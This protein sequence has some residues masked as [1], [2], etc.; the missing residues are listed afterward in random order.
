[1][2]Q[3]FINA[4]I[5]KL[6]ILKALNFPLP[7]SLHPCHHSGKSHREKLLIATKVTYFTQSPSGHGCTCFLFGK[8]SLSV[9]TAASYN[10]N[11]AFHVGWLAFVV[12]NHS[13][14]RNS[15]LTKK[16]LRPSCKIT[17]DLELE[18]EQTLKRKVSLVLKKR[19]RRL[20]ESLNWRKQVLVEKFGLA[21][22]FGFTHLAA[23]NIAVWA[24]LVIWDSAQEWTYFVHVAQRGPLTGASP[25]NLRGFPG[26]LTKQ[27][28]EVPGKSQPSLC[29]LSVAFL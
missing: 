26:S 1:V 22:R 25:L 3:D 12:T 17:L 10:A 8:Y 15:Q 21:A 11:K 18:L 19:I 4:E 7:A 20:S 2:G 14:H 28:R 23:T 9:S 24:R 13:F 29:S 27:T 16:T 6:I 5:A